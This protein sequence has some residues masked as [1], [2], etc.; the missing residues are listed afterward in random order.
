MNHKEI[1]ITG[2]PVY[3]YVLIGLLLLTTVSVLV[4]GYHLGALTVAMALL[5][6]SVKVA[7]VIAYFMHLRSE[8]LFLKIAVSGVFLIFALVIIITFFDYLFR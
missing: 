3:A 7:T 8:S 5:I 1:H 6:A 2:Y 4:T